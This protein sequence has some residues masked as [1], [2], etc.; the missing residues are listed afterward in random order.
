MI[1]EGKNCGQQRANVVDSSW[2]I[3]K[4]SNG[5]N[6]VIRYALSRYQHSAGDTYHLTLFTG[7]NPLNLSITGVI[8]EFS[9]TTSYIW[10][11]FLYR[12]K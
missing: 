11:A 9:T 2:F 5:Q 7:D 8:V 3:N 6:E 4:L 1:Y 12:A 10:W